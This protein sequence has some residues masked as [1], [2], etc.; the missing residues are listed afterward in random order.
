M[1]EMRQKAIDYFECNIGNHTKY[2]DEDITYTGEWVVDLM[3]GFAKDQL[4][5]QKAKFNNVDLADVRLS[6]PSEE[7]ITKRIN[8]L[9]YTKHLDD[10][11]YNDGV[12]TGFEMGTDWM[13]KQIEGNKA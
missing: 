7:D 4:E 11:Q 1:K 9:P 8:E 5:E 6:L 2:T 3:D 13:R 10:G 12:L